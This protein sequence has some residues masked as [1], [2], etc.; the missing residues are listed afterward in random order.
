MRIRIY[1]G[2]YFDAE[3]GLHYNWHRYYD[4]KTG[5][6]LTP[7][8]IGL[9]GGINLY[10]YANLNPINSVDPLGLNPAILIGQ[11]AGASSG[12]GVGAAGYS[13]QQAANEALTSS[14]M[15][16]WRKYFHPPIYAAG[17]FLLGGAGDWFYDFLH[18]PAITAENGGFCPPYLDAK[19]SGDP[20]IVY[21]PKDLGPL[22]D[23]PGMPGWTYG[24]PDPNLPPPPKKPKKP[25]SLW[26]KIKFV[27]KEGL[28]RL[29]WTLS[30]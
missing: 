17:E 11:G 15:S 25:Q 1:A 8:P 20:P 5:R 7:D 13:Q 28:K 22:W 4:P 27:V 29:P 23:A 24:S 26:E 21:D 9:L 18:P 30:P 6:Y 3:T 16:V 19:G 14:V 12:F 2:Q 10:V